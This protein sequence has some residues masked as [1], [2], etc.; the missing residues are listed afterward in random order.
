RADEKGDPH[1]LQNLAGA[2]QSYRSRELVSEKVIGPLA[3]AFSPSTLAVLADEFNKQVYGDKGTERTGRQT[4]LFGK[5]ELD[6]LA[7]QARDLA[8]K[9]QPLVTPFGDV[10]EGAKEQKK[11]T[12]ECAKAAKDVIDA[13]K[14]SFKANLKTMRDQ[15]SG[16]AGIAAA[17]FGR[18]VTSDTSANIDAPIHVAHAFTT[19]AS[20]EESD[21]LTAVDDLKRDDSDAGAD[22]IQEAELTS[23]IYYGY[24]VVDVPGLVAN[25]A[26][27][28]RGDWQDVDRA[29]AA[30]VVH[31][32]HYLIAEISPGAKLGSTAPYG[33]AELML[34]EMGNRQ[35]R[36]LSPAFRDP[37]RP[38]IVDAIERLGAH[39]ET[40]DQLYETGETRR[41]LSVANAPFPS[42]PNATLRE[43]A[44]WAGDSVRAGAIAG[45]SG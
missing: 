12:A 33:R 11:H 41:V 23:G 14:S 7:R 29:L 6:E 42:A 35:P 16:H 44:T 13:W 17:L 18:M 5:P 20:E 26:G 40:I 25:T 19:H 30:D 32:L 37:S 9:I 3:D 4:L 34:V 45:A 27:C 22:T 2:A 28:D 38:Q 8:G 43:L 15:T 21:Y 24:V 39:V 31:N 10:P 36:S 1:A